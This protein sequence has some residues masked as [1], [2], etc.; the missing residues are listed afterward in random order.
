M[1]NYV[2]IYIACVFIHNNIYIYYCTVYYIN[3]TEFVWTLE[4]DRN[5]THTLIKK[6]A[7]KLQQVDKH[8]T[9]SV[10]D[11]WIE[12]GTNSEVDLRMLRI[13]SEIN[14]HTIP[15]SQEKDP[16]KMISKWRA[17]RLCPLPG[18]L[19]GGTRLFSTQLTSSS[20]KIDDLQIMFKGKPWI[21]SR[22]TIVFLG[23]SDFSAAQKR[24]FSRADSTAAA[25]RRSCWAFL[26]IS[27]WKLCCCSSGV[28]YGIQ[29]R[30]LLLM[31]ND[32]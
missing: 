3:I 8:S 22:K 26:E 20:M 23:C 30:K 24:P 32:G 17:T 10:S 31:V 27:G 16:K 5:N 13:S 18:I 11:K 12:K 6:C 19:A 28:L 1:Y 7:T 4:R 25:P 14:T 2:Y 9:T 21:S 15:F 29:N